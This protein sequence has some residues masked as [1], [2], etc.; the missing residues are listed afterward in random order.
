MFLVGAALTP[1]FSI[2]LCFLREILEDQSSQKAAV[3]V[4]FS[5]PTGAMIGVGCYAIFKNWHTMFLWVL[6]V[7]EVICLIV[8]FLY[9]QETP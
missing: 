6:L 3:L 2:A 1:L 4:Q 9:V 7:P 8:T 5:Y